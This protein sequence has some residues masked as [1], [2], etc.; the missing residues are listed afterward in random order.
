LAR[1]L[2]YIEAF[3][4]AAINCTGAEPLLGHRPASFSKLNTTTFDLAQEKPVT[5]LVDIVY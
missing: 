3:L 4:L 1:R 5:S 2:A